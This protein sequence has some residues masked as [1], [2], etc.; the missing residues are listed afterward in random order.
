LFQFAEEAIGTE[1][2]VMAHEGCIRTHEVERKRF[3]NEAFF[4][5]DGTTG[6]WLTISLMWLD[7]GEQGGLST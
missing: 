5:L 6:C 2:N 7:R 3:A 4:D 1:L